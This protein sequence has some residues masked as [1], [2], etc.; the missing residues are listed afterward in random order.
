MWYVAVSQHCGLMGV[1]GGHGPDWF[2]RRTPGGWGFPGPGT[3]ARRRG[4]Q[5]PWEEERSLGKGVGWLDAG[6]LYNRQT[7]VQILTSP[8]SSAAATQGLGR[9]FWNRVP[10]S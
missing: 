5:A 2:L 9:L 1:P 7:W 4:L 8:L 6:V 3:R 10:V